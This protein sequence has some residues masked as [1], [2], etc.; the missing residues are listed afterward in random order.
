M[1]IG[2][3]GILG[4]QNP[5]LLNAEKGLKGENFII[6]PNRRTFKSLTVALWGIEGRD[7]Y[8]YQN[9]DPSQCGERAGRR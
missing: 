5:T 8:G 2:E 3:S 4:Y 6:Q 9:P 7:V 1:G